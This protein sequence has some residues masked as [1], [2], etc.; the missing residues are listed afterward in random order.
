MPQEYL[1]TG[2]ETVGNTTTFTNTYTAPAPVLGSLKIEKI[3]GA[4]APASAASK[5]YHFTVSGPNGYTANVEI[6]GT[7]SKELTGLELGIYTVTED[8]DDAEID[9]YTLSVS[10]SGVSI[11][12]TDDTQKTVSITNNYSKKT[13]P[14]DTQ[15]T[16]TQPTD[17]QPTGCW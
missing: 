1:K 16:D 5:T 7:G 3:L 12:L 17:T 13:E 9:G 11:E 10:N 6:Q 8:K 14:T 4:D 15:P 2:E